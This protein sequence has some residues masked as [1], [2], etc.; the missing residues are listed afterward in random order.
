MKRYWSSI[1]KYSWILLVCVVLA[2]VIGYGVAKSLPTVY[3]GTATVLVQTGAPGTSITTATSS[4]DP[5]QSLTEA[6]T[7]AAEIPN[8]S[9]ME[10]VYKL[11]PQ[12]GAR[13][14]SA[15]DLLAD[16]A[17]IPS[18][19]AATI[20]IE[21]STSNIKDSVML[22][23][24]VANGFVAYIQ[25]QSQQQ[26][27][28]M[29]S[30]LQTQI[31]TYQA[32]KSNLEASIL[33][34]GN[35]S[36]PR[37]T[38]YMNDLSDVTHTIDTLQSQL[39]S[40]PTTIQADVSVIQL[41]SPDFVTVTTKASYIVLGAVAV[42]LVVGILV[43]L[44][45]IFLDDR[46][47]GDDQVKKKLGLAYLGGL[48]TDASLK[49]DP[50]QATGA[51]LQDAADIF[52]SLRLTGTLSGSLHAPDGG[53]LLVTSAQTYEGK[54]TVAAALA[55]SIAHAGGSVVVV[56]GNLRQP[57]THLA[58]NMNPSNTGL[59][60]LL[61]SSGNLND[62]VLPANL[63]GI[64]VLP[65]GAPVEE[66]ALLLEKKLPDI[67]MQLRNRVDMVIIDGPSLLIGADA[68]M[69]ATMADAVLLV[70]DVR[71][72]RIASLQRAK[73][74][75]TALTH[76]PTGIVLNRLSGRKRNRFFASAAPASSPGNQA[77]LPVVVRAND[78]YESAIGQ[79]LEHVDRV[80]SLPTQSGIPTPAIS[81]P[82]RDARY[83]VP[84]TPVM[85]EQRMIAQP[86]MFAPRANGVPASPSRP[87]INE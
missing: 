49:S 69:L 62:T 17:A 5:T 65:G 2:T 3:M 55:A 70:V 84:A 76:T 60:G 27:N 37:Y 22:A 38:L 35:S 9:V 48:S 54:T 14:Y 16:V 19:A 4:T 15:V 43:M 51:A 80:S 45:M 25:A 1:K 8:T 87:G 7:Y 77:V 42:G 72:D 67:L 64:W 59:S 28:T 36:D 82:A 52:A 21:A 12:I 73:E 81:Q 68:V 20:S 58:F 71:H 18:T 56:E 63:P 30:N 85:P 83:R 10:Y 78:G 53:V 6:N 33:K 86:N 41:A 34:I 44:L 39:V 74:L 26:L 79:P 66:P 40:L 50:T 61:K 32:Q 29:R 75:L 24:D 46:L 47:Y 13:G 23:N 11:Y 57:S 31:N